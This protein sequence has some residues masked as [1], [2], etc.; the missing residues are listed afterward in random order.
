MDTPHANGHLEQARAAIRQAMA[1]WDATD[2]ELVEGSRELLAAAVRD[3]RAFE[4][5]VR[6]GAV[7]VSG[8]LCDTLLTIKQEIVQAT[9]VVDACV[10]FHRGLAVRIGDAAPGYDAEG[11]SAG[12]LAGVEP[13]VH[14]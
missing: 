14:A 12:E 13:E 6:E 7:P 3:M 5:A 2:L 4:S 1:Q 9:R 8:G 11:R 10:A